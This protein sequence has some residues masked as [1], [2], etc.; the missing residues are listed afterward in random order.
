[1]SVFYRGDDK[2]WVRPSIRIE[3]PGYLRKVLDQAS[4]R[5]KHQLVQEMVEMAKKT[6]AKKQKLTASE[7]RSAKK[8]QKRLARRDKKVAKIQKRMV[9][10]KKLFDRLDAKV[11]TLMAAPKVKSKSK[12]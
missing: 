10:A 11:Q 6:E 1:M 12:K 9:K 2:E 3:G 8:E 4:R 5:F 7:K